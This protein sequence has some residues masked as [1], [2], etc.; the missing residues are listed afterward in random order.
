MP[1]AMG[2][3]MR[4]SAL[5]YFFWK[6]GALIADKEGDWLAPI[7]FPGSEELLFAVARFVNARSKCSY[8]RDLQLRQ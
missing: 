7:H 5:R 2:M 1:L 6:P 8:R 4:A 3:R